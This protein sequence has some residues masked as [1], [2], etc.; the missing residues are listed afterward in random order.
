M[1][2][3]RVGIALVAMCAVSLASANDGDAIVGRWLTEP[4]DEDGRARIEIF[5]EG[6]SYHGKIV[7]LEKPL[8]EG[9]D[10]DG[11]AG[12]PKRDAN[13]P[14]PALQQR[15]ILGLELMRGFEYRGDGIW[16]GGEVYDPG[17]G[18]TYKCKLKLLDA[19]TLK[20]R[21]YIGVSL[22]GR[23][24]IWTRVELPE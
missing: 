24:S 16:A 14:D 13:N 12:Q 4:D 19:D 3:V 1:Q 21:G 18:K 10:E 15:P 22:I 7:W 6:E 23:T 9:S 11:E 20:V 8:Y 2:L 17:K 5:A